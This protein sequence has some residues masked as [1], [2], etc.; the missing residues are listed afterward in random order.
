MNNITLFFTC[1]RFHFISENLCYNLKVKGR[2]E[3]PF[4]Y[5]PLFK[6]LID[7]EMTKEQLRQ[8]IATS[9]R[10]ITKINK[11]DYI[12]LEVL[13]RIC[14]ALDVPIEAVIEHVK[15]TPQGKGA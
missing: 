10:T 11:G 1:Q 6:T 2:D 13:D 7:K 5:K 15:E 3:M 12:A 9:S 8:T 14:T 4:T